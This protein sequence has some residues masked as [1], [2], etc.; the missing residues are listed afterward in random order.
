MQAKLYEL[1]KEKGLT[2]SQMGDILGISEVSYRSK[3]L[4]K[5]DFKLSEMFKIAK[6]FNKDIGYIFT[7]GTSRK[8]K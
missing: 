4:D 5:S 1:R 3:E 7:E 2:Q 8:V 6:L